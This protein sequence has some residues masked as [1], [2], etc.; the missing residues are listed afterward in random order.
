MLKDIK[1][2]GRYFA[3]EA[4]FEMFQ[5]NDRLSIIYGKNGSGKSTITNAIVHATGKNIEGIDY[6]ELLDEKGG[7]Y[8]DKDNIYVFNE[9]YV[10]S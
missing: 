4:T 10:N 5:G 9:D 3:A 6:A 2:R 1:L 7:Q 8:S